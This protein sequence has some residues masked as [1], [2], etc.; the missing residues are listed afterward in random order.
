MYADRVTDSMQKTID[1]TNRRREKQMHYN[2]KNNMVPTALIKSKANIMQQ[3]SVTQFRTDHTNAYVEPDKINF[4]ADP[5]VQYMTK[6]QMQNAI[7][8]TKKLTNLI[9]CELS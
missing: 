9:V 4:A 5:V 7:T 6:P 8:K 3:A 2:E 1:E